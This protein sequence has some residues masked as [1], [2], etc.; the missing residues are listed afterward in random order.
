MPAADL[1]FAFE[2]ELHIDRQPTDGREEPGRHGDR[3]Q[4]R[5]FVVGHASG[6]E[7]SVAH[8]RRPRRAV[9]FLDRVG[10]LHVVMTVHQYRR[11]PGRTQPLVVDHRMAAGGKRADRQRSSRRELRRDPARGPIDVRCVSGIS[12]DARDRCELDELGDDRVATRVEVPE[13]IVAGDHLPP[14]I[15]RTCPVIQPAYSEAKNSTPCAMSAG[16]PRRLR[17]IRSTSARCPSSPYD[18]HCRSV[19]A[20]DRT[21]PGA[22]L[23][24]V[25]PHGPSSCASCRV[26]PIWAAFAAAYAWIPVRL[27]PSPAPLEMLTIRPFPAAFIAGATAC[28]Q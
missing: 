10:R 22:M 9:P 27:T 26:S 19:V 18:C 16:V 1:L 12:A 3:N 6:V 21:N 17:A 15:D 14:S 25:I 24:T 5:A 8:G 23:L 11:L 13:H 4:H 2:Q 20:F 28:E 7:T